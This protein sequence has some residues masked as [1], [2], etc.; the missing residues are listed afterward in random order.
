MT[1]SARQTTAPSLKFSK[2]CHQDI[3]PKPLLHLTLRLVQNFRVYESVRRQHGEENNPRVLHNC[4]SCSWPWFQYELS[5]LKEKNIPALYFTSGTAFDGHFTMNKSVQ[6]E[7]G[8][9]CAHLILSFLNG[10]KITDNRDPW[11]SADNKGVKVMVLWFWFL[12][13]LRVVTFP[14]LR[15]VSHPYTFFTAPWALVNKSL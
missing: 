8:W 6:P 3:L 1:L 13:K 14:A 7:T 2:C 4:R 11:I 9:A 5:C 12:H 10:Q 15:F